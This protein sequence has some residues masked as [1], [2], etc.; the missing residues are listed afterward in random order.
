MLTFIKSIRKYCID[1]GFEIMVIL[2]IFLILILGLYYKIT[3]KKGT[4]NENIVLSSFK[5]PIN[6]KQKSDS[7]GEIECRKVIEN[8]FK[9]PFPK[10]RPDFLKNQVTGSNYNLEL[11][12]YN[13]KL[14][15]AVEYNGSQHYKY[16]SYFHKNKDA[17]ENQKYRDFMKKTLCEKNG[18]LLIEVPYTIKIENIRNYIIQELKKNGY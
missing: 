10:C 8:I 4:W 1:N 3:N 9:I 14:K 5:T 7:K 2:T 15:I 17:F 6:K 11:D 16:N 13:D 18:I 12:C